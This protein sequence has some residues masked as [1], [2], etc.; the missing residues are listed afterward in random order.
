MSKYSNIKKID[1]HKN[2]YRDPLSNKIHYKRGPFKF[3]CKT[4]KITEAK[5]F[6]EI[7]LTRRTQPGMEKAVARKLKGVLHPFLSTLWEEEFLDSEV[8]PEVSASTLMTYEQNW[9]YG[10]EGF[11]GDKTTQDLTD[12]NLVNWKNWY[13]TNNPKRV[14]DHTIAHFKKFAKYLR[15]KGLIK[16]MPDFSCFKNLSK[17]IDRNAQRTKVG[18]VYDD[19]ELESM[20][21]AADSEHFSPQAGI[22]TRVAI[23]FGWLCGMRKSEVLD[24][25]ESRINYAKRT[26]E[27]WSFKN[28]QWRTVPLVDR[29]VLAIKEHRVCQHTMGIDTDLLFPMAQNP[30]RK[31]SSQLFDKDWKDVKRI[32]NISGWNVRNRA[33]FHDLRH[34]CAT[35]MGEDGWPAKVA[36]TML[37]MSLREFDRTYSKP[38]GGKVGEWAHRTFGEKSSTVVQAGGHNV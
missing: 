2:F 20:I 4:T 37:D 3:S 32:A 6:A 10:M 33:R 22:R 1:G 5:R 23:L 28:K 24:V 14:S 36:C 34:T 17:A 11:W 35:K 30:K 12:Q 7:E 9:K 18:R 31:M 8:R 21:S 16:E 26:L 29:L 15:R 25:R 19:Q 27:V 38:R 13:L